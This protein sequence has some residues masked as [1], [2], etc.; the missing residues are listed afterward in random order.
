M[1]CPLLAVALAGGFVPILQ[2]A[3]WSGSAGKV[4]RMLVPKHLIMVKM[5]RV[6]VSAFG[7]RDKNIH[8]DRNCTYI[9]IIYYI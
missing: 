3:G 5:V 4:R 7:Y 2:K 6:R 1:H 9:Y 8:I